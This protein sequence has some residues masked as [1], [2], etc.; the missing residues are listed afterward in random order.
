MCSQWWAVRAGTRSLEAGSEQ[1]SYL[2]GAVESSSLGAVA[3]CWLL[4]AEAA[5]GPVEKLVGPMEVVALGVAL[6]PMQPPAAGS[7]LAAVEP[8][9]VGA[10]AEEAQGPRGLNGPE[11][12]EE[13]LGLT[14]SREAAFGPELG[15]SLTA[16]AEQ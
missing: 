2:L 16:V 10:E 11:L 4:V 14:A 7:V 6:D 12:V 3:S 1:T 8:T 13:G 9:A 5:E 15:S